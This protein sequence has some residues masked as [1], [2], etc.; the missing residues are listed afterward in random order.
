MVTSGTSEESVV[1]GG[2]G[3]QHFVISKRFRE[4]GQPG[5][6]RSR[7]LT[8][9]RCAYHS[10]SSG[11]K[12]AETVVKR[13][14]RGI[15]LTVIASLG[16]GCDLP[17]AA[18]PGGVTAPD[19]PN[20]P[21]LP[22]DEAPPSPG[23]ELALFAVEPDTSDVS[24]GVDVMLTGAGFESGLEVYFDASPALDVFVVTSTIAIAT[25]PP[26]PPG[27]VDVLVSH[28]RVEQG[29]PRVLPAAFRYEAE[30]QVF[31]L[32]PDRGDVRGGELLTVHGVGFTADTR[33]FI[34]GRPAIGQSVVDA[35]TLTG[36]APPGEAGLA[37]LHVVGF[38]GV[39]AA[40][41]AYAYRASP[42]V[43]SVLPITGPPEGGIEV[44]L[45]GSGLT[46]DAV[47]RFG[48][49]LGQL[50]EA[51]ASGRWLRVTAP[52]G[53]PGAVADVQVSTGWGS[54]VAEGAWRWRDPG[55]DPYLLDCTAMFP[56]QG[57]EAGGQEVALACNGLVYGVAV[58][59]GDAEAEVLD[60]DVHAGHLVVAAPAGEG[61]VTVVVS[62]AYAA[63]DVPIAYRYL[64][65]PALA[66]A[67]V[68]PGTG[69]PSGGT[70]V[71][72]SGSGFGPGT[73]AWIGALPATNVEVVDDRTLRATTPPGAPG[74]ADAR[75]AFAGLEAVLEGAFDYFDDRLALALV[76]PPTAA[77]SGGTWLRVYGTGF[78][79]DAEV[80]IGGEPSP[81]IARISSSELH[82]RSPRL[83]V[84]VH[85]AE[86]ASAGRRV[87]LPRALTVYDPRSGFGGTWGPPIDDALNVTVRGTNNYGPIAG[88]FVIATRPDGARLTGYTNDQGQVTLSALGFTGPVDLTAS[89]EGFTSYSIVGFDATN[90]T[91]FLRQDPAPPPDGG[92]GGPTGPPPVSIL[93]GKVL[94]M[95][96]YV[97]APPGSCEA[98]AIA[99]TLHCAPC[100]PAAGCDDAS[101]AC[102]DLGTQGGRCAAACETDLGC[103]PGYACGGTE[104]G[105][106]CLPTPGE[107]IAYCNIASTSLFG[108]EF[109]I[110]ATAWVL[111]GGTFE[112]ESRNRFGNLGIYCF[113]GYRSAAGVFTPTALGVRRHIFIPPNAVV[114]GLD[115]DLSHPLRR[116]LRLRLQDP[117]TWP[118][119][120]A[121][122]NIVISLNLGA[123]GVIP[124]SRAYLPAG[125]DT[126]LAP[127]QL[128]NLTRDLYDATFF[129]YTTL[130]PVTPTVYPRSYNI[131]QRVTRVVEDRLPVRSPSG[132]WTLE[133]SHLERD[134]Y[135]AWAAPGGAVYAVGEGGLILLRHAS[136]WTEQ[137][138]GTDRSLRAIAGRSATDIW[139][140][141]DG[142][143]VRRWSGVAWQPVAAPDDDLRA[144]VTAPGEDVWAAGTVRL[145]RHDGAGWR[146]DGP[147]AVQDLYGLALSEQGTLVAVGSHGRVFARDA[148][149]VWAAVPAP[150]LGATLRAVW[151]APDDAEVV[152]VGDA[153]VVLVGSP[154]EGLTQVD[155]GVDVDLTAL[156]MTPDGALL[157]VGDA[158]VAFARGPDGSWRREEIRDYRSRAFAIVAPTDGGPVRVVGGAAF[159]LGPFLH[160]PI[161]TAPLHEVSSS[162]TTLGWTWTGGPGN[163]LTQL[164]IY[165]ASGASIWE[166]M[167]EGAV[168]SVALPDLVTEAGFDAL[169]SGRKRLEVTRILNRNFDIDGYTTRDLGIF[170]RDSW[171]INT[172]E[173]YV[174]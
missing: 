45:E 117:P 94:G 165:P 54:T 31:E 10:L 81:L 52:A 87:A 109:P 143:T 59:F 66:V 95:D 172:G 53:P 97:V 49:A 8:P 41:R 151:I 119:G 61:E 103:P 6:H 69:H 17:E 43:A 50:V 46:E 100:E 67:A 152:A 170:M 122:P 57:P 146:I 102:V 148:S 58:S 74:L 88:A 120:V 26:H 18:A 56:R 131:V 105:A 106:R 37:D 51:S 89:R 171:S 125:E 2:G 133:G 163:Q 126:W 107:R 139:A 169:G 30:L 130:Q 91:V 55:E 36:I 115:V 141:G 174:P 32:T 76:T 112:I 153:G 80:F 73:L 156:A 28:P 132:E 150:A 84:G 39:Y 166:L 145:W 127:R 121:P 34:G 155:L 19:T 47:V 75:V 22:P 158:G 1:G 35:Q 104:A 70:R 29:E 13:L 44:L 24:G 140:V 147:S 96:K 7:A 98:Y 123:D 77:Q 33:F 124:F 128:A 129:F 167:V 64:G 111:P 99:E 78:G 83:S 38:N 114:E 142:G 157:I 15:V 154:T 79:A 3:D 63:V 9:V 42:A 72:L 135:G 71:T 134:L 136:G 92:G 12:R 101:F 82:V 20:V 25:A 108:Y 164:R 11:G 113:G 68:T 86:V 65:P 4:R 85:D 162:D 110:Q 168:R 93:R 21:S 144:V 60:V 62:N 137:S 27:L 159:I 116:T 14:M 90:A 23:V 173:F 161:V 5:A 40:R 160:F 138:S 118:G 48:D 149:E 16:W